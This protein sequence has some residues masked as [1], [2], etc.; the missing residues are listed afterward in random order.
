MRL[1]L[2]SCVWGGAR[3]SLAAQGHDVV[4]VAELPADPGDD[5][6]LQM[7]S[8]QHRVLVTLDKDFGELAVLRARPHAGIIRLIGLR[9]NQQAEICQA[10]LERHAEALAQGAIVSATMTRWRIRMP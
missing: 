8:D 10:I 2:D 9:A 1:L 3:A 6:I 4:A 5:I 7:A